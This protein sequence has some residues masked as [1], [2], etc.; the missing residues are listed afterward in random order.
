MKFSQSL[1][2]LD[3]LIELGIKVGLEH[4]RVLAGLMGDPQVR[5][6][7]VLIGGTNGKGSTACFLAEILG[8]AGCKV[9]LYTSPHL[10]DVTE[11]IRIGGHAI[12]PEGFAA[13]LGRVRAVAEGA[14][15]SGAA[16]GYP[17]YFEALTLLAFDHFAREEVDVAVLEVG[18]GGRLDCTNIVSPL[19][20]VVTNIGLDH[21]EWLGQGLSNIAREKAGIF[22]TRVPAFTAERNTRT[23]EILHREAMKVGAEL[24]PLKD[25]ELAVEGAS[26]RLTAGGRTADLPRPVMLGDHQLENAALAVRCAWALQDLGWEIPHEAVCEGV[27]RASW[28]GRLE[29]LARDP[30]TFL[31]G[32]HNTDGCAALARFVRGRRE[33]AKV[34]V[35]GAMRDKPLEEMARVLFPAFDRVWATQVPM[36]RACSVSEIAERTGLPGERC[37]ADPLA[38]L[39]EARACAGPGG[40]VVVAGSLYLVGYLKAL[41]SSAPSRSWGSGL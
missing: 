26:W 9:G 39:K 33:K 36:P 13:G 41:S 25:C 22:R 38:S 21:E 17:T 19:V 35:F 4:T 14:M 2:Y 8:R 7:S 1:S 3:S 15:E 12:T 23:L 30:V 5:F 16:E 11:R 18:L 29:L 31:D 28:P 10:V 20:T 6:P 37:Q 27:R 24:R 40:L 34:L 32:A